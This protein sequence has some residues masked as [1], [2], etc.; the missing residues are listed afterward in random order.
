MRLMQAPGIL[1]AH[2]SLGN[3]SREPLH[4]R[5]LSR[6]SVCPSFRFYFFRFFAFRAP[7]WSMKREIHLLLYKFQNDFAPDKMSRIGRPSGQR[8]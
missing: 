3:L 1:L 2:W 4:G 5:L 6:D 8:H 7:C